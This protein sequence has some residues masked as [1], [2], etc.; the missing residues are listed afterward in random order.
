VL[1]YLF[2]L[3]DSELHFNG[4]S[5]T[6]DPGDTSPLVVEQLDFFAIWAKRSLLGNGEVKVSPSNVIVLKNSLQPNLTHH[7]CPYFKSHKF[8]FFEKNKMKLLH[9]AV[10][11]NKKQ[12]KRKFPAACELT[13]HSPVAWAACVECH[14]CRC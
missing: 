1:E 3:L 7:F 8:N 10:N 4:V 9:G 2:N 5:Y 6:L 13:M 11:S 12:T 14:L